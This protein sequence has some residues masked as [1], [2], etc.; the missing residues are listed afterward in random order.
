MSQSTEPDLPVSDRGS[1]RSAIAN[2]VVRLHAEHFGRGPTRARAHVSEDFV[3]VVLEDVFTTAERTL[4]AAGRGEEVKRSRDAFNEVLGERFIQAV[5]VATGRRVRA[6]MCE[7]HLEPEMAVEV[8]I[9][10][11][12]AA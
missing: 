1:A 11:P 10:E 3:L 9:L 4:V 8:F 7:T 6:F 5:E 12:D 2:A